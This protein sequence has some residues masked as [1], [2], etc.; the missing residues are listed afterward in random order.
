MSTSCPILP[1][2]FR[3]FIFIITKAYTYVMLIIFIFNIRKLKTEKG[4]ITCVAIIC[5]VFILVFLSFICNAE[6]IIKSLDL[7]LIKFTL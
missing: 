5:F 3:I 1:N 6:I 4:S 7:I 2:F